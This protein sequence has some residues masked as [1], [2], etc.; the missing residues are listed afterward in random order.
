MGDFNVETSN[1]YIE[2]IYETHNL[3]NNKHIYML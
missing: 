2:K 3:K 1:T